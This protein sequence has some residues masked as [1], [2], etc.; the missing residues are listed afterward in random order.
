MKYADL[1]QLYE[2]LENTSKRL[3]KIALIGAF[4]RKTPVEQLEQVV[5]LLQGLVFPKHAEQK[6]G[7]AE[8]S[9]IKALG[10]ASGKS[11]EAIEQQW[12]KI[13]DLGEVAKSV[14]Q[15]KSQS[16]LFS[17]HL[18]VHKVLTN[19]CELAELEGAGTVDKKISLITELLSAATGA[20]AKYIIRTLL[21]DLRIGVKEGVLRDA[22]VAAYFPDQQK[23]HVAV[24]QDAYDKTND[25]GKVAQLAAEGK[26]S[27]LKGISIQPFH[28]VKVMLFIKANDIPDAFAQVGKPAAFEFKYDGF[29]LQCH[30]SG[31]KVRL[32]TRRLEDVTRQFPD[33][34]QFVQDHVRA[35]SAILD[36]E[37][38]GYDAV[39]KQYL[40]FQSISQRIKRKYGIEGMVKQY[41]IEVN[42]F[43]I[44]E[45]EGKSLL[46]EPFIERRNLLKK[47]VHE[48]PKQ[49]ILAKQIVTGSVQE[50]EQFFKESLHAGEEG[51]M[52][53]N[54]QGIYKPGSRVGYG[55]KIKAE[56]E[57]LDLVIVGAEWGTGKRAAW[58][59]S[60]T[61]ACRSGEKFLEIGKVGTGI[62]EKE[63]EEGVTFPQL[64]RLLRPL[65]GEEKGKEVLI[66]PRIVI[67]V[68]F[69]EI[70]KS[71]TYSSGYALRFPRLLRIRD[72]KGIHDASE[73][74]YVERLYRQQKR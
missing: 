64:T 37:A 13:G 9:V 43:D 23:E 14:I 59:S 11:M 62:K 35:K 45:Y 42:V 52:A 10:V 55:I 47:I 39:T 31:S 3:G 20:E 16:T 71:P 51:V 70:Q 57:T 36:S 5:L 21:E 29:R 8:R 63:E 65:M 32:F 19:L 61:L 15:K 60:F 24:V 74:K 34:V 69:E 58:L 38:V 67:E 25:F 56:A 54:L 41:P 28:P 2:S 18:T 30:K 27:S 26:I 73:L 49:I 40:P 48:K 66:R 53:K 33:V 1:V 44:L 7:I 72:D 50:A 6:I 4:L 46:N 22:I 17:S 12:K 68:G